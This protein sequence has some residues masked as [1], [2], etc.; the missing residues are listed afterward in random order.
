MANFGF[1]LLSGG[2]EVHDNMDGWLIT[3][4]QAIAKHNEDMTL[5]KGDRIDL[6]GNVRRRVSV[7][8]DEARYSHDAADA[9]DQGHTHYWETIGCLQ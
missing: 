8:S 2:F 4:D 7:T 5:R 3:S 6:N 9:A 1:H